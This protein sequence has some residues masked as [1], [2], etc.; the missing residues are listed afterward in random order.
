MLFASVPLRCMVLSVSHTQLLMTLHERCSLSCAERVGDASTHSP[1][2]P[3]HLSKNHVLL[4]SLG[5]LAPRW[6]M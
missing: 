1:F 2:H 4:S 6:V 3:R 5:A